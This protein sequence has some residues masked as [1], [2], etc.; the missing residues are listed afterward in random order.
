MSDITVRCDCGVYVHAT[1]LSPGQVIEM[2]L[3]WV[4]HQHE[5]PK[6]KTA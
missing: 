2:A 3:T 4:Q 5:I 1:E 6:E